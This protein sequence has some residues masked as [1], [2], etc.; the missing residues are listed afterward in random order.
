MAR[1][2]EAAAERAEWI[3]ISEQKEE[4]ILVLIAADERGRVAQL[5]VTKKYPY[6]LSY[7]DEWGL[8]GAHGG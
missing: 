8:M 6:T 1:F 5:T 7:T 2:L 4:N 3:S